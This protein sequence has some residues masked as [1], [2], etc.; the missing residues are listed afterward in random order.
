[1]A[2]HLP[3]GVRKPKNNVLCLQTCRQFDLFAP[4]PSEHTG[5]H[6]GG[7]FRGLRS[8]RPGPPKGRKEKGGGKGPSDEQKGKWLTSS[9]K[10]ADLGPPRGFGSSLSA[11]LHR[12]CRFPKEHWSRSAE[13]Q[14]QEMPRESGRTLDGQRLLVRWGPKSSRLGR[15]MRCLHGASLHEMGVPRRGPTVWWR[16]VAWVGKEFTGG[17]TKEREI[18]GVHCR[19]ARHKRGGAAVRSQAVGG[20]CF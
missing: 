6:P 2:P 4:R 18:W 7:A 20:G 5:S 11:N 14:S 12:G 9:G 13:G 8:P 19:G 15:R 3:V 10:G 17:R 1:M 16:R